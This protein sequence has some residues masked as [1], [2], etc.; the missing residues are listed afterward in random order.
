MADINKTS[1]TKAGNNG[2]TTDNKDK[3][4]SSKVTNTAEIK[5]SDTHRDAV[6][7]QEPIN[8]ED[9]PVNDKGD[10]IVPDEIFFERYRELP[11]NT[12][13]ETMK[14]RVFNHG[15]VRCLNNSEDAREIQRMGAEASNAKQ[16]H[17][18]SMAEIMDDLLKKPASKVLALL[19]ED[20]QHTKLSTLMA[21]T[22]ATVYDL[23]AARMAIEAIANGDTKAATFVRDSAGDKPVEQQEISANVMTDADRALLAKVSKRVDTAED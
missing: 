3:A 13:N 14:Y 9:Y 17:R 12:R 1:T 19:T 20:E 16:A 22:D 8:I 23:V 2:Q 4:V 5:A 7:S 10:H 21:G 6:S 11:T 18:R 15:Y